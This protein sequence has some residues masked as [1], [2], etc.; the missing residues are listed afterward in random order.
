MGKVDADVCIVVEGAYPFVAGGVSAWID[1]L[2]RS[3]HDLSFHVVAV[4]PRKQ[5]SKPLYTFSSNLIALH[6]INLEPQSEKSVRPSVLRSLCAELD[7]PLL[8]MQQGQGG[9]AEVRRIAAAMQTKPDISV[10]SV[11]DSRAVWDMVQHHYEIILGQASFPHYWWSYRSM[12]SALLR[13]LHAPIP[14]ARVYHTIT[15]GYAGLFAINAQQIT[16]RP[17]FV[18][19]HGIYTNERR[20]ELI[21]ADWLPREEESTLFDGRGSLDLRDVW[22][23]LFTGYARACYAASSKIIT[24]YEGNKQMQIRDGADPVKLEV[25]P[26]G[27]DPAR[28][29]PVLQHKR[30]ASCTIAFIGR[31]VPIKDV[32]TFVRAV[33]IVRR[34]FPQLQAWVLGPTD[35]DPVY[36]EE[37]V[38]LA[39]QLGCGDSLKFLGSIKVE[40]YMAQINVVV[41]TSL[42]ESQ[43]LVVLEAG[44]A[45][46]PV[47][48]T[49]VGACR[50]MILGTRHEN[51]ALGSGGAITPLA[52]S[53]ATADS[54]AELLRN[55]VLARARGK[56]LRQRVVSLYN[57]ERIDVRYARLYRELINE[58][59]TRYEHAMAGAQ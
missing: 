8:R 29:E 13:T 27:I 54:I 32:K 35:E 56:V 59:T 17:M 51:P 57:K 37:C 21:M 6:H 31:V 18:T 26:N 36:Y 7:E 39:Q 28:F 50:E 24:L 5:T 25:I 12:L 11:V 53:A 23:N 20:I 30:G 15:T 55:P 3:H 47:V 9:V 49:D 2:I 48:A 19:E 16:Q 34:E 10:Q 41:L 42:S 58:Q 40:D 43:P 22:I 4:M 38:R 33:E 14:S 45:G 44:A 46:L 52:S 1:Q